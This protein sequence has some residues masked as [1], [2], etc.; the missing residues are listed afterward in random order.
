MVWPVARRAIR[1]WL[2]TLALALLA[3]GKTSRRGDERPS[4]SG[5]GGGESECQAG[6]SGAF[7]RCG[8]AG[9]GGQA[10]NSSGGDSGG[11]GGAGVGGS[12]DANVASDGT[13]ASSGNG[14]IGG[15]P[16]S[17]SGGR[18]PGGGAGD[19]GTGGD[20]TGDS[21]NL[22]IVAELGEV[23]Y[24]TADSTHLYALVSDGRLLSVSIAQGT[25]TELVRGEPRPGMGV[26]GEHVYYCDEG[27]LPSRVNKASG[28]VQAAEPADAA[29]P[30]TACVE[31]LLTDEHVYTVAYDDMSAPWLTRYP[32]SE[33]DAPEVVAGVRPHWHI[34]RSGD[35]LYWGD[36][37]GDSYELTRFSWVDDNHAVVHSMMQEFS[38]ENDSLR[39][40]DDEYLYFERCTNE[41]HTCT[42]SRVPVGGGTSEAFS[43]HDGEARLSYL[44]LAGKIVYASSDSRLFRFSFESEAEDLWL[45]DDRVR[46]LLVQGDSLYF[47]VDP[48]IYSLPL[49]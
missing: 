8:V 36:W 21:P 14:G 24:L 16:A 30:Q 34:L 4:S 38:D 45:A 12:D 28:S 6:T 18:G 44:A 2:A 22:Q 32:K 40:V 5:G 37:N 10:T 9:S 15:V 20:R 25:V 42:L 46:N 26:D 17:D 39:A 33:F 47:T 1:T 31:A 43:A 13:G 3:C 29:S 7:G 19:N 11:S 27:R 48:Y 41:D 49:D 35:F 23:I